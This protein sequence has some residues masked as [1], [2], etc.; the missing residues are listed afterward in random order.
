MA[1][2]FNR[3]EVICLRTRAIRE[4]KYSRVFIGYVG[5]QRISGVLIRRHAKYKNQW[6]R[7]AVVRRLGAVRMQQQV[8]FY[9]SPKGDAAIIM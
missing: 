7:L 1:V 6:G 5:E 4:G 3:T 8:T 2:A 9:K